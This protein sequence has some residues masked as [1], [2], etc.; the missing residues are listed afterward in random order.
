MQKQRENIG[1][2]VKRNYIRNQYPTYVY[3]T[4][5]YKNIR[6]THCFELEDDEIDKQNVEKYN[7]LIHENVYKYGTIKK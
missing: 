5:G 1:Y 7:I 6:L 3:S 4:N 2:F